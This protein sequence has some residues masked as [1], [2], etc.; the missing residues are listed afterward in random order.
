[1]GC[2]PS[3]PRSLWEVILL[4]RIDDTQVFVWTDKAIDCASVPGMVCAATE[5]YSEN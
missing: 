4:L 3:Q 1:M 2:A 5:P